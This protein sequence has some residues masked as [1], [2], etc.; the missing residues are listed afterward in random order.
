[1]GMLYEP[2]VHRCSPPSTAYG[3]RYEVGSWWKCDACG[4]LWEFVCGGLD[5][6]WKYR[7]PTKRVLRKI[8][9]LTSE[10]QR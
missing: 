5:D 7:R 3:I 6:R 4:D 1:M 8:A 9:R 2:V 10:E